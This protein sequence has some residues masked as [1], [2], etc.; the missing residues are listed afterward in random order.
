MCILETIKSLQDY[1]NEYANIL[2]LEAHPKSLE[3]I[4]RSGLSVRWVDACELEAKRLSG[5]GAIPKDDARI[6]DSQAQK[7]IMLLKRL[8]SLTSSKE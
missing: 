8:I 7:L 6:L 5:H 2:H 3:K 1:I 4:I